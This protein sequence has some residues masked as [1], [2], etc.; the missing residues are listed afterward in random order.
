MKLLASRIS[1]LFLLAALITGAAGAALPVLSARAATGAEA[2]PISGVT[3]EAP[4]GKQGDF[5]PLLSISVV[6]TL[7]NP[8]DALALE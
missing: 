7:I 4:A 3:I 8:F 5:R 2:L 6:D 1:S